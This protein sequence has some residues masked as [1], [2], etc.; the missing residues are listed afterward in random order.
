MSHDEEIRLLRREL[1]DLR[2]RVG[3]LEAPKMAAPTVELS[4]LGLPPNGNVFSTGFSFD[5]SCAVGTFCM[6]TG[7]PRR[8]VST[9]S[10]GGP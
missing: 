2:D 5:C 3:R 6:N 10:V 4:K 1:A 7:C 8:G 9:V